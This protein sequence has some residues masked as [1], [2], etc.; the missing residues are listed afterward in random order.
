MNEKNQP[1]S[2]LRRLSRNVIVLGWVSLLTDM[3]SEMLYPLMPLFVTG[4]LGASPAVLGLIDGIAEGGSSVLRWTLVGPSGT[5]VNNRGFNGSD[6]VDIGD[7]QLRLPAGAYTLTIDATADNVP[8]Y[9]FR[10]LDLS[11]G[12]SVTPGTPFNGTLN[13]AVETDVFKFNAN[14]GDIVW[15]KTHSSLADVEHTQDGLVA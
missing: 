9:S 8:N 4:V 1:R 10:L 7:P 5:V 2:R 15:Q 13:P 11:V 6:S 3:A 14:T 12:T